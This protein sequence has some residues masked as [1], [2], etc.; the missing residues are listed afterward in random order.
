MR[1][2]IAAALALLV[3]AL[4]TAC[5]GDETAAPPQAQVETAQ[6]G[7][8]LASEDGCRIDDDCASGSF[9][10]QQICVAECAEDA[11]CGAGASCSERA[12]CVFADAGER[13][14]TFRI[15]GIDAT[16]VA[17]A[18][19]D[20]GSIEVVQW[21][22]EVVTVEP[23]SPFVTVAMRTAQPI[24]GGV[25]LYTVETE[26]GRLT[27]R[28]P[29]STRFELQLPTGKAGADDPEVEVVRLVTPMGRQTIYLAPRKPVAGSYAGAFTPQ[30]FGGA[31][32]TLDLAIRTQPAGV[33]SLDE[34][35]AAW[36]A[37]PAESVALV[38]LPQAGV[39]GWIERPLV[40]DEGA[41]AWVATF[42]AP[43]ATER[44]FGPGVFP[45]AQRALRVEIFEAGDDRLRGALADRWY[46]LFERRSADGVASEGVANVSGHFEVHRT[47]GAPARD[48][49]VEA[50]G[51]V[52]E[53][54]ALRAPAMA[55]CTQAHF[56][57]PVEI[58]E[59]G[60]PLP[61]PCARMESAE[62][63]AA[64]SPEDRARCAL[65]VADRALAGPTISAMLQAL[66]DPDEPNPG[67]MN[68]AAFIE[69]CASPTNPL[70]QPGDELLCVRDLVAHAYRD[71]DGTG[72]TIAE[73][74]QAYD[75][76]TR[77][78]Y[79][80]RQ[81]AAFHVDTDSRLAWLRT[82]EAPP[83]LAP[84]LL[85]YNQRILRDWKA[86]VFDAHM[87]TV[88]GQIDEAGMAV[89][90]RATTDPV[91]LAMRR[92]MLL[93]VSNSW[94]AAMDALQLLTER[95]NLLYQ[96]D[97]QRQEA[98]AIVRQAAFRLY[99]SAAVLQEV[100]QNTGSTYLVSE[101]GAGFSSLLQ[102]LG[103]LSLPFDDLLFARD[104]EVV[105]A[106]SV[107]PLE[108]GRSL[109]GKAEEAARKAVQN[110][111]ESVDLVLDEAQRA[112]ITEAVL[113]AQYEDQLLSLRDELILLCG[114]PEGCDPADVG[115]DPL[116]AI[117][118]A[119]GRCGFT[120]RRG[121]AE[122][123]LPGSGTSATSE[124]GQALLDLQAGLLAGQETEER[125][126]AHAQVTALTSDTVEAFANKVKEWD[127]QRR[128]VHREI[129]HLLA[130]IRS[131]D[132]ERI[133]AAL[134][135]LRD[136]QGLREAA[137]ARQEA[138][139][140]EWNRIRVEGNSADLSKM[141]TLT[142]LRRTASILG[143]GADRVDLF[144]EIVADSSPKM[145]GTVV[146]PTFTARLAARMPAFGIST[147]LGAAGQILDS[148]AAGLSDSML[149]RQ[150]VLEAELEN[151]ADLAE[152]DAMRTENDIAALEAAVEEAG[153]RAEGQIAQLQALIDALQ[154]N[155]ELDLAHER[156]LMELR[157]RRDALR[158]HVVDAIQLDWEMLQ[159]ELTVRQRENA[160]Y[161]VVQRAQLIEGRFRSMQARWQNLEQ[162][163][164][165]P[166][167]LFSF[168]N[169]M[170]RAESRMDTARRAL[171]DWL[172]AL[173][174]YAVRPF[175]SQRMAIL[176]ARNPAQL[177]AIAN[178]FSR[179]QLVCGGPTTLET[180]E[181]SLRDD[182]LHMSFDRLD[183]GGALVPADARFRAA[184]ARAESSL[185][186]DVIYTARETV[187]D[188]LAGGGVL[189]VSFDV[190]VEGFAN[191]GRTCSARID[192]VAVQLV[193]QEL[194]SGL[195]VVSVVHHGASH[196]RSCQPDIRTYV[197]SLGPG[198][199]AFGPVTPFRVPGRMVSPVAGIG[200]WTD[201]VAWNRTLE[202]VPFASSYTVLIDLE[203]PSNAEIAWERLE[204]IRIQFR[205]TY[206][207]VF[208]EGQ[209]E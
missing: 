85:D 158:L 112:E 150:A 183:E 66:L 146:D 28:A 88:F 178:E 69:A 114:L 109:L 155:L 61:G 171:E 103:R 62:A 134:G 122:V 173:E 84:A 200:Q 76:A 49:V 26:D 123:F 75:V 197:E 206:Q 180:V 91:A 209:C 194:G 56:A 115:V 113:A 44:F 24:P 208:P 94:R 131:I 25:L 121:S 58:D 161:A 59:D 205:F 102:E 182:L 153:L 139:V 78:A 185:R 18:R 130:E 46:G 157:D 23:L 86:N 116:C 47:A 13:D 95:W 165:S 129:E 181:V 202:G 111:A 17:V 100:A 201:A 73:L 19:T 106:R 174:Y 36:L 118:T 101:F 4:V 96:G 137:Y 60:A 31:G 145:V 3:A 16:A 20:L 193:G 65:A 191:L 29:G 198:T 207:D 99:A 43:L 186:S 128:A 35:D 169:R 188:R 92:S 164:G 42:A 15:G 55:A 154:R 166:D 79:V 142:G 41:D 27:R 71:V 170:A 64:A 90:G 57:F 105:V 37:V 108:D 152:L 179:L 110:A 8:L 52:L 70:C 5:G 187:R 147:A 132:D 144:A 14:D 81:L 2:T 151:L 1:K 33:A 156:D 172:V 12:R 10:F 124:A 32:I 196:L 53:P 133:A 40:W 175:V 74:A 22:D 125:L 190:D 6:P 167:V 135:A 51:A 189:A 184:L 83:F 136:E 98:A 163:L 127:R 195:P 63:F 48:Q 72:T 67:G 117:P 160:Y 39:T 138:A 149:Y 9:C 11:D 148:V 87:E 68:F 93:D 204:D 104:A 50:D 89:L 30:V 176:L 192:S 126:H 141:T 97:V 7:L 177:E 77:E 54:V 203:H 168:A 143:Y 45:G 120:V 80:G 159:A 38:S 34:A 21:P 119:S 140:E 82:S 162:L 199:T 107:D